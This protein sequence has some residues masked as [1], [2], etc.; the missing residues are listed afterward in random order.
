MTFEMISWTGE[1]VDEKRLSRVS[2]IRK[3]LIK[4]NRHKKK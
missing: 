1:S 2:G 3:I 4:M